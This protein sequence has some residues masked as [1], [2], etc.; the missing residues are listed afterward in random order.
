MKPRTGAAGKGKKRAASSGEL[1]IPKD[2]MQRMRREAAALRLH[3]PEY[4]ALIVHSSEVIRQSLLPEGLEDAT[5]LRKVL[6]T[7]LLLDMVKATAQSVIRDVLGEHLP[8][9]RAKEVNPDQLLHWLR[10][11]GTK[12]RPQRVLPSPGRT[13]YPERFYE[14]VP[15]P[16]PWPVPGNGGFQPGVPQ[17]PALSAPRS[18]QVQ[19]FPAVPPVYD[20]PWPPPE[21]FP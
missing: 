6:G 14:P 11:I 13:P 15:G 10:E 18:E 7:P 2:L 4:F 5:V 12:K 17:M 3:V 1:R 8:N 20:L 19:A 16:S 21:R 9:W